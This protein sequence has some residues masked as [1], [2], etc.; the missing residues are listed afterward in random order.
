MEPVPV[1][2]PFQDSHFLYQVKWDGVRMLAGVAADG[3]VLWNRKLRLRTSLYPDICADLKN[4]SLPVG[5]IL[6][7]E[8]IS[9]GEDG[10][11]N[12]R[13]VLRRDLARVPRL[14]IAVAYIV[15]DCLSGGRAS[16]L[17]TP[18]EARQ[19]WIADRIPAQGVVQHTASYDDGP[20]LF[21]RMNQL[22]ME[23]IV[24]KRRGSLYYVGQKRDVWRKVKCWRRIRVRVT[25]V[26]VRADGTPASLI[27]AHPEEPDV[28]GRCA[29]GMTD[30][31][32]S[33]LMHSAI[34]TDDATLCR[35][36]AGVY[37]DVRFLEWTEA[38]MLRSPILE[39]IEFP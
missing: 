19:Q 34:R 36:P 25:G 10:R 1:E 29:S 24:A 32:W 38:G 35:L 5:T 37:A 12:F 20:V 16:L 33:R 27:L 3:I 28:I 14:H 31:A 9:L 13:R 8:I 21:M 18:I 2:S 4:L 26:R 17:N 23:G 15:F 39:Q 30:D 7:G 22:G 11:P 6:D